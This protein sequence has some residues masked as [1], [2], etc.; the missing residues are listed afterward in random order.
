MRRIRLVAIGWCAAA[1]DAMEI[2]PW[3]SCTASDS[4]TPPKPHGHP[5]R[6]SKDCR[7]GIAPA[8]CQQ[9]GAT[10]AP[11]GGPEIS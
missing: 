2:A 8:Q 6:S 11:P 3:R 7:G 4:W 1:V 9:E 5:P 10:E